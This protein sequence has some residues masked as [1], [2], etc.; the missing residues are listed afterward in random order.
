[1]LL[2]VSE[3]EGL[4]DGMDELSD[5][6]LP[7]A[8][9]TTNGATTKQL[10]AHPSVV[11]VSGK[12]SFFGHTH[13][14]LESHTCTYCMAVWLMLV[15]VFAYLYPFSLSVKTTGSQ[16]GLQRSPGVLLGFLEGVYSSLHNNA[17]SLKLSQIRGCLS[18]TVMITGLTLVLLCSQ[19]TKLYLNIS[20]QDLGPWDDI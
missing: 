16:S 4:S 2:T 1:M 10:P 8:V 19:C 7:S 9:A 18:A 15:C 20:V 17:I 5:E 11:M 6:E 14:H 13:N 3:V 12:A